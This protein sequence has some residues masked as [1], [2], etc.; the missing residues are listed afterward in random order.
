MGAQ[1]LL[2]TKGDVENREYFKLLFLEKYFPDSTRYAGE[3]EFLRLE[4][5]DM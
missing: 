5:K 3:V 4:H 1:Q 2:A